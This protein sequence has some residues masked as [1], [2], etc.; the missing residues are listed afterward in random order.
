MEYQT[1]NE[2]GMLNFFDTFDKAYAEYKRDPTV[3]KISFS[4]EKENFRWRSK[5]RKDVWSLESETHLKNLCSVYAQS[6]EDAL[7]SPKGSRD[8]LFW[9]NQAVFPP[10]FREI[11]KDPNLSEDEKER[12]LNI[13]CLLEIITDREFQERYSGK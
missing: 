5:T 2:Q 10:K 12:L 4:V 8:E 6:K 1:R 3:W 7:S 9:V 11:Y 13:A